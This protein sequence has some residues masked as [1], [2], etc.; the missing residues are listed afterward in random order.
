V[1]VKRGEHSGVRGVRPSVQDES[2]GWGTVEQARGRAEGDRA[3]CQIPDPGPPG[4]AFNDSSDANHDPEYMT[5]LMHARTAP[6][7]AV[8][9]AGT[10]PYTCPGPG[11]APKAATGLSPFADSASLMAAARHKTTPPVFGATARVVLIGSPSPLRSAVAELLNRTAELLACLDPSAGLVTALSSVAAGTK[12]LSGATIVFVTD[13]RPPGLATRLRRRF[14]AAA[15]AANLA[16]AAGT[17]RMH[18]A[19]RAIVLSSAF[20][21]DDDCGLPLDPASPTLTAAETATVTAAEE[22]ARL[23]TSLGGD[24]VVLRL[25]W[26][27]GPAEAITHHVLSAARR[28]WRL[29]DGDPDAWLAIVAETDA[30]EA[31][32]PALAVPP[33]VYN[34]T[35]DA[36]VTQGQ[37]NARL[38]IA[39]G[40]TLHNIDDPSW[41]CGGILFGPSR[42]ITDTTFSDLTGW[43]PQAASTADS[44]AGLLSKPPRQATDRIAARREARRLHGGQPGHRAGPG[45]AHC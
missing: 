9:S 35:D 38:E 30:A 5:D 10:C 21:Y 28:G 45:T 18:G 12:G 13:P 27:C 32:L 4:L 8:V 2:Y 26:A 11:H 22:A 39:L 40:K 25:G 41:G 24:S 17:A 23:F 31:V 36:P 19:A 15:L 1:L 3:C 14:R 37:L 7:A 33:G 43:H 42:E 16:Q 20:T 29:I 44:L 34:V 6:V